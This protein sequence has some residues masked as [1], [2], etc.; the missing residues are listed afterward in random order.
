MRGGVAGC[1]GDI[2][3]S[4]RTHSFSSISCSSHFFVCPPFHFLFA[5]FRPQSLSPFLLSFGS[6]YHFPPFSL[7]LYFLSLCLSSPLCPF[8]S[9]PRPPHRAGVA[10]APAAAAAQGAGDERLSVFRSR[11]HQ[12][13]VRQGVRH[14]APFFAP[15]A[16]CLF[17]AFSSSLLG[18]RC[19]VLMI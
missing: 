5:H 10:Q 18:P 7:S 12:R 8:L 6:H 17:A 4:N 15:V 2:C 9:S 1:R 3:N 11:A 14:L 13:A 16:L 19:L